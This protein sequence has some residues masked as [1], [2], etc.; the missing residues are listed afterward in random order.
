VLLALAIAGLLGAPG[1]A[2]GL[3]FSPCSFEPNAGCAHVIVPLDRSGSVAGTVSLQVERFGT[4]GPGRDGVLLAIAGGPGQ[5]ATAV[6]GEPY[7]T[8]LG[9]VLSSHDFVTLD[10][11]GTGRSGALRCPPL[12]SA[13]P[14]RLTSAAAAC[15]VS[16]GPR[17]AFY[18]TLD[19]VADIE[20]VRAA[21]GVPRLALYG[22]SY[23]SKVALA[24]ATRYPDHVERMVLDSV[25]GA[26]GPDPLYRDTLAALPR[27]LRATCRDG[28][29]RHITRDPYGDLAAVAA[30]DF[31][32]PDLLVALDR[33]DHDRVIYLLSDEGKAPDFALEVL[34]DTTYLNDIGEK[35]RWYRG[36]GVREYVVADPEGQFVGERRLQRWRLEEEGPESEVAPDVGL[37]GERISSVV[38][39]FDLVVREGW[40]RL[41]D[42]VTG[43]ELPLLREQLAQGRLEAELRREAQAQAR[44]ELERRHTSEARQSAAE[45]RQREAELL[46]QSE[47]AA[48]LAAEQE[49][50]RLRQR[51]QRL[52]GIDDD[53]S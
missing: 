1:A 36:I 19:S 27:V 33:P 4:A 6:F 42:P 51:L 5:S 25:V 31:R 7:L 22:I 23:G 24:Y 14:A 45:A 13:T 11:R 16:L 18:T 17:R 46:A 15:A 32:E 26:D 29:C 8:A 10:L 3:S 52:N 43:E 39:P 38:L 9:P 53:E 34:S 21:L 48:R 40:V 37:E 44:D 28:G 12:E 20:A 41:V 30:R 49:L 35:R 47:A 50:A 2:V